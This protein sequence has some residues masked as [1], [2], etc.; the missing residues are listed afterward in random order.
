[1]FPLALAAVFVYNPNTF[2]TVGSWF[3]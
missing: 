2:Q 3:I 1:V